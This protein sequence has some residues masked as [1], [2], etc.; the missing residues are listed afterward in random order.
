MKGRK[1]S[2]PGLPLKR[3]SGSVLE[4]ATTTTS[5]CEQGLEQPAQDHRIDDVVHLEF[6]EAQQGGFLG[7]LIRQRRDGVGDI[8]VVALDGVEAAMRVLHEFMEMDALFARH[9]RG[10]EE[11][12]HQHGFAAPDLA[13]Q[14]QPVRVVLRVIHLLAA[15]QFAEP[16]VGRR[17][18]VGI[19]AAQLGPEILQL[20][21]GARLGGIGDDGPGGD[22]RAVF[23]HDATGGGGGAGHDSLPVPEMVV[24]R[25]KRIPHDG[26]I[27]GP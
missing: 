10:L 13:D 8:G 12:V 24:R 16:A 3:S 26:E 2:R 11:Q 20:L 1:A 23:R 14:I 4:V 9:V 17:L 19:V 27:D 18:R 21:G 22:P 7:D 15:Q 6:V 5:R 25:N